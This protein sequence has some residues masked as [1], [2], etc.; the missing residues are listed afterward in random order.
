[1]KSL[2]TTTTEVR[3]CTSMLAGAGVVLGA[4][5]GTTRGFTRGV[6]V[7]G[8][9]RG[10]GV[11]GT[12]DLGFGVLGTELL[13]VLGAGV[14]LGVGTP[15]GGAAVGTVVGTAAGIDRLLEVIS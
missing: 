9:T 11:I 5:V 3:T 2:P 8:I 6:G 15:A 13:V 10:V 7:L 1:M 12:T 4:G 14:I